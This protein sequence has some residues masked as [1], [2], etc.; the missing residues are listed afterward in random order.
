MPTTISVLSVFP[1][2]GLPKTDALREMEAFFFFGDVTFL[3]P[4]LPS[5]SSFCVKT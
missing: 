3:I 2:I 4:Y 5:R 1:T